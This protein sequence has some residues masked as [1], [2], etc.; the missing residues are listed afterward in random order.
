MIIDNPPVFDHITTSLG[1]V[2]GDELLAHTYDTATLRSAQ[3]DV[4]DV[5]VITVT[6]VSLAG[7]SSKLIYTATYP[8]SDVLAFIFTFG[9]G[10]QRLAPGQW[11]NNASTAGV[12]GMY[13]Q[14]LFTAQ[15]T[16]ISTIN[17]AAGDTGHTFVLVVYRLH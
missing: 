3:G 10:G 14:N 2:S 17:G 8:S 12:C 13:V 7:V 4:Y 1:P 16:W 11:I 5:D 9:M 15:F 6:G